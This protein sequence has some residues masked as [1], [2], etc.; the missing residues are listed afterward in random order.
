TD[1]ISGIRPHR[2]SSTE[3]V[4][5]RIY[6]RVPHNMGRTSGHSTTKGLVPVN[7]GASLKQLVMV[8]MH[9]DLLTL[10]HPRH[11]PIG[12]WCVRIE[13]LDH[14]LSGISECLRSIDCEMGTRHAEPFVIAAPRRRIGV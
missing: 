3:V 2:C 10:C 14:P 7:A 12:Q 1:R 5:V 11:R 9:V 6:T 13:V 8:H 4:V